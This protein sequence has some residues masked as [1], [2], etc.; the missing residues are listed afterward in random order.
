MTRKA[1]QTFSMSDC[2]CRLMNRLGFLFHVESFI[3]IGLDT[4]RVSNNVI[5]VL[6]KSIMLETLVTGD[7]QYRKKVSLKG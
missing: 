4:R 6:V 3:D 1:P 7:S 2:F 5:L